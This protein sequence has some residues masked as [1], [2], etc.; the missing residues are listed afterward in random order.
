[1]AF[2]AESL[3]EYFSVHGNIAEVAIMRDKVTGRSR[4]FAF[5]QFADIDSLDRALANPTHAIDGRQVEAKR[6][7][8]KSE[9]Q[10]RTK[11]IFVGGVPQ[12]VS[13]EAFLGFFSK[14]GEVA[15]SQ[16]LKDRATGK[17]RGFGFITFVSDESV[18]KVFASGP[19]EIGG[20]KVR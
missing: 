5:V 14:Y 11:K 10:A 18:D 9:I 7:V 8:P 15:E 6:A 19:V 3:R 13:D 12:T 17:S 4:G 16:I 20:R 1:M 2:S